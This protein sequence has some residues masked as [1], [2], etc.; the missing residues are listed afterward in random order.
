M[1]VSE[2]IFTGLLVTW[3]IVAIVAVWLTEVDQ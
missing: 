2:Q 1:D 3:S